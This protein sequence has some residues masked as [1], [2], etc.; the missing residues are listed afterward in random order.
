M[1]CVVGIV[2]IFA[3]HVSLACMGRRALLCAV[4][5]VLWTQDTTS[6]GTHLQKYNTTTLQ[7]CA[8]WCEMTCLSDVLRVFVDCGIVAHRVCYMEIKEACITQA[9]EATLLLPESTPP[10]PPP[11]PPP[12]PCS[13]CLICGLLTKGP[14]LLKT[15]RLQYD[16]EL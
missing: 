3:W 7:Q 1:N 5:C 13:P 16:I 2:D 8:L 15:N 14:S 4:M 11:P 6:K 12:W 10:P 9:E